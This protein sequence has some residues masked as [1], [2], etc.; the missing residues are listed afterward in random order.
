MRRPRIVASAALVLLAVCGC[1]ATIP[2]P[3]GPTDD[4]LNDVVRLELDR[5]WGFTGLDGVVERPVFEVERIGATGASSQGLWDCMSAA[6]FES[7]GFSSDSGLQLSGADST[8][9]APTA[10]QQLAYYECNARFPLIDTLTPSQLDFVY[11]YYQRWLI[12]CIESA[13]YPVLDAPSR[14]EFTTAEAE[15]GWRWEPYSA[16]D[17]FPGENEYEALR[18]E[19]KPTIP[20]IEGWSQ[21]YSLFG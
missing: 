15:Y 8:V 21:R 11:D 12:P 1:S 3:V 16:L 18:A 6:G 7:W 5:Q 14:A 13:G 17:E 2:A 9:V 19:C 20:G 4:E 10:E